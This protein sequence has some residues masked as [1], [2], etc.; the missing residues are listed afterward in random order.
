MRSS[1]SAPRHRGSIERDA[2]ARANWRCA[3][4]RSSELVDCSTIRSPVRAIV[5]GQTFRVNS[6][7][8]DLS[9]KAEV[10]FAR[11]RYPDW[12]A[13]H[14]RLVGRIAAALVAARRPGAQPIERDLIVLAA[15]LHDIGRSPLVAGDPRDHTILGALIPSA[16]SSRGGTRSTAFST[17][18]SRRGPMRRS[19]STSR[20]AA[21]ARRSS[22][23]TSARRTRHAATRAMPRRSSARFRWRRPWS[24]RCSR[25]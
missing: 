22:H 9:T 2:T 20:T 7:L 21:V 17:P 16:A 19:W 14:S 24:V 23:S 15:Y 6:G 8:T 11:Y 4:M 1:L 10:F 3:M 13:T 5:V 25:R 18:R 12:L